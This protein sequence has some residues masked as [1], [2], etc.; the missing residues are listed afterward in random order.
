LEALA[1]DLKVWEEER[2][3]RM[4]ELAKKHG[5]KVH[6]VRRRMLGL[7]TY[8]ARRK[9]SLYNTKVSR[10]MARLNAGTSDLRASCY[11]C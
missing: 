7:S 5:M 2:E 3:E 8:G 9:P 11:A 1:E 10:I 6:E 4:Q